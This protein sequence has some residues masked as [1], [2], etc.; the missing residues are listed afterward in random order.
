MHLKLFLNFGGTISTCYCVH[1][2]PQ[3]PKLF[4]AK[5]T[6]AEHRLPHVPGQEL[7]YNLYS[8]P[9]FKCD[10]ERVI[11]DNLSVSYNLLFYNE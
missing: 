3:V 9:Y 1:V 5:V 2:C 8:S 10:L 4:R 11:T 7:L 6:R